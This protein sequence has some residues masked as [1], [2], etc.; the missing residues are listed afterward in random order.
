MQPILLVLFLALALAAVI[1]ALYRYPEHRM[2]WRMHQQRA[3]RAPMRR[4]AHHRRY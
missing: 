4:N 1:W 2:H 3:H